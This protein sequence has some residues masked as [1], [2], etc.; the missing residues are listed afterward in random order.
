M[1]MDVYLLKSANQPM[2]SCSVKPNIILEHFEHIN[3]LILNSHL[4]SEYKS[5]LYILRNV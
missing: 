3:S 4:N 5:L 2:M 1:K